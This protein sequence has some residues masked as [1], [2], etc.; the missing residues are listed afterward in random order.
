MESN[1]AG[2]ASG[3][4][5]TLRQAGIATGVAAL[6]SILASRLQSSVVSH[7]SGGP[8]AARAHELAHAVSQGQIAWA[9]QTAPPQLRGLVAG[10]VLT[11]ILIRQRDFVGAQAG[12]Q[13]RLDA[14]P[15]AG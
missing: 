5:S 12:E 2:M 7:L 13:P 14:V 6:G 9:I 4:N 3:I 8:L 15:V 1:L 11:T 10:A